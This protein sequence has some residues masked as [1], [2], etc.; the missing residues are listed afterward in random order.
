MGALVRVCVHA[1]TC[2]SG[3]EYGWEQVRESAKKLI[4]D[5]DMKRYMKL[6]DRFVDDEEKEDVHDEWELYV[7]NG[8]TKYCGVSI[9][10]KVLGEDEDER[11]LDDEYRGLLDDSEDGGRDF[12]LAFHQLSAFAEWVRTRTPEEQGMVREFEVSQ[13]FCRAYCLM[14]I[15]SNLPMSDSLS[16]HGQ[17]QVCARA[18]RAR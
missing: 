1:H 2:A 9:G 8:A 12:Y 14:F 4:V 7:R 5:E 13:Q 3:D 6:A 16:A 10:H 15:V 17:G 18:A 11:G